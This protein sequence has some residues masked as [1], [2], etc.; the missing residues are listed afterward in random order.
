MLPENTNNYLSERVKQ[1]ASTCSTGF[2]TFNLP[3]TQVLGVDAK[4]AVW[5]CGESGGWRRKV[6]SVIMASRTFEKDGVF[7]ELSWTKYEKPSKEP[8][9]ES[10]RTEAINMLNMITP[11]VACKNNPED[12]DYYK[13][14]IA[15][16]K[17]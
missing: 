8:L 12:K 6:K 9:S 4:S 3:D 10:D 16:I 5:K 7:Y 14:C 15:H 1:V 11:Y 17:K 2:S 13:Q